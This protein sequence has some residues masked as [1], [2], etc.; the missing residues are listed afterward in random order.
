[1]MSA[2]AL[3]DALEKRNTRKG[4]SRRV[5]KGICQ[6]VSENSQLTKFKF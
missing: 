6:K 4:T 3:K 1:M 5:L 2:G